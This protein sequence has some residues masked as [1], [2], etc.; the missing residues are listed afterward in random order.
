VGT[1]VCASFARRAACLVLGTSTRRGWR[2][3]LDELVRLS[4]EV[5]DRW[6]EAISPQRPRTTS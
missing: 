5:G 3:E 1:D 4:V 2:D 6:Q